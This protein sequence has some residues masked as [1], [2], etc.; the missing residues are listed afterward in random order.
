MRLSHVPELQI[1]KA[2][3]YFAHAAAISLNLSFGRAPY[4]HA[5]FAVAGRK[6]RAT[7]DS[8]FRSEGLQQQGRVETH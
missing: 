2:T 4:V 3:Q 6:S 5:V 7:F 1:V 8:P